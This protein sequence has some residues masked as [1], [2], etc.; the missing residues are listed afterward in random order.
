MVVLSRCLLAR[1]L[2]KRLLLHYRRGLRVHRCS[3][4]TGAKLAHEQRRGSAAE[5]WG[6]FAG[7]NVLC[8]LALRRPRHFEICFRLVEPRDRRLESASRLRGLH[9][10]LWH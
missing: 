8:S 2:L 9:S 10:P 1:L 6:H 5:R 4:W 7:C 3:D